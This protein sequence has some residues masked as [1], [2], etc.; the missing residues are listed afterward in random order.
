MPA[1]VSAAADQRDRSSR[2]A[3]EIADLLA[4]VTHLGLARAGA[5]HG[6]AI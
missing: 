5:A 1:T 4:R 6:G 3:P 2:R